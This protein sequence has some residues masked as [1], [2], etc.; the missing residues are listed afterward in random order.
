MELGSI[1]FGLISLACFIVPVLYYQGKKRKKRNQFIQHFLELAALQQLNI[2]ANDSWNDCYAIGIDTQ[3]Q[4]L[5]YLK[6]QGDKETISHLDLAKVERCS[7][8]SGKRVVR[9]N[10]IVDRLALGFSFR[11]SNQPEMALEFYSRE[12]SSSLNDE[13]LLAEKWK[14]LIES[15][16]LPEVPK[17]REQEITH[18]PKRAA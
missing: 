13:L 16:L 3:K 14:V 17:S 18:S 7:L 8:L 11:S 10:V 4:Q 1:I 12:E 15:S 9:D 5:F 6:R 2:S